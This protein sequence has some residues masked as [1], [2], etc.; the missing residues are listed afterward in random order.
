[1]YSKK[2]LLEKIEHDVSITNSKSNESSTTSG[3]MLKSTI[4]ESEEWRTDQQINNG[5]LI[6]AIVEYDD[7]LLNKALHEAYPLVELDAVGIPSIDKVFTDAP[8]ISY[9]IAHYNRSALETLLEKGAKIDIL[10]DK[11][12]P[13]ITVAIESGDCEM[14]Q[15]LIRYKAKLSYINAGGT[16]L[17][18]TLQNVTGY[19]LTKYADWDNDSTGDLGKSLYR[20]FEGEE[21]K[22]NV[23]SVSGTFNGN[24]DLLKLILEIHPEFIF[25]KQND[26]PSPLDIAK[27]PKLLLNMFHD[28]KGNSIECK[29]GENGVLI[30][31]NFKIFN[32]DMTDSILVK[33]LKFNFSDIRKAI[34][35]AANVQDTA[36]ATALA[37]V[38]ALERDFHTVKT[39]AQVLQER[40][41][42]QEAQMAALSQEV[43]PMAAKHYTEIRYKN[44]MENVEKHP[45]YKKF[46]NFLSDTLG[47]TFGAYAS[48]GTGLF[49]SAGKTTAHYISDALGAAGAIIPSPFGSIAKF[50]SAL[51]T[52]YANKKE[53]ELNQKISMLLPQPRYVFAR[54]IALEL[55]EWLNNYL[56]IISEEEANEL[57][58]RVCGIIL[59]KLSIEVDKLESKNSK[60][61]V[62]AVQTH[63]QFKES[64]SKLTSVQKS[65]GTQRG[66]IDFKNPNQNLV[67]TRIHTELTNFWTKF[68]SG[69][70]KS[71]NLT[72]INLDDLMNF[73][74]REL[75]PDLE[76]DQTVRRLYS[77][78]LQEMS[79]SI[80]EAATGEKVRT[81]N[82]YSLELL[83]LELTE[84]VVKSNQASMQQ[85]ALPSPKQASEL[86]NMANNVAARAINTIFVSLCSNFDSDRSVSQSTASKT[87]TASATTST[88][89]AVNTFSMRALDESTLYFINN[90][91][92]D[93][94]LQAC[95]KT[96]LATNKTATASAT[97]TAAAGTSVTASASAT[98]VN[99]RQNQPQPTLPMPILIA[100]GKPSSPVAASASK[101]PSS[102]A[103]KIDLKNKV[104]PKAHT[105]HGAGPGPG[106]SN[107][108]SAKS[109][110]PNRK[111]SAPVGFSAALTAKIVAANVGSSKT[112]EQDH[113]KLGT[114]VK[115]AV[116]L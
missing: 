64:L 46:F 75:H 88:A 70:V 104:E 115:T 113:K 24:E 19:S 16:A 18:S 32:R 43:T 23:E 59:V 36:S 42:A 86:S 83:A 72:K 17:H 47:D 41:A 57:A 74:E 56:D 55:T 13:P 91:K 106:S 92:N 37:A 116:A 67:F 94:Q 103:S 39:Q 79:R 62:H 97:A 11:N 27:N 7:E 107:S 93:V 96:C 29:A 33:E 44:R 63:D 40:A 69:F 14:V 89:A 12:N 10:D 61:F 20:W 82:P 30:L 8:P 38:N 80:A 2:Q 5:V 81:L 1:M 90:L 105:S 111:V 48:L 15:T 34:Y 84:M 110:S 53:V 87:A 45:T 26:Q 78:Y 58:Q 6:S 49:K 22:P 73:F 98:V 112:S 95:L 114:P 54:N 3:S 100:N 4:S 60:Q 68:S 108:D 50:A 76:K 101:Q 71:S 85:T 99:A 102:T 52:L 66:R 35:A 51:A 21:K 9:A 28:I 77:R 25:N 31:T 65:L 109:H